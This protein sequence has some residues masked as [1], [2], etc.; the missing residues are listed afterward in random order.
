MQWASQHLCTQFPSPNEFTWCGIPFLLCVLSSISRSVEQ[1]HYSDYSLKVLLAVSSA[2]VPCE[3][4]AVRSKSRVA[5]CRWN[6]LHR[7][8]SGSGK[9]ATDRQK[10]PRGSDRWSASSSLPWICKEVGEGCLCWHVDV[11]PT[12]FQMQLFVLQA[13][14]LRD[15]FTKQQEEKGLSFLSYEIAQRAYTCR[16]QKMESPRCNWY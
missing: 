7:Q 10:M 4:C 5:P 8:R 11:T 15:N 2:S 9:A 14:D 3:S 1:E 6:S 12:H 16:L 13:G